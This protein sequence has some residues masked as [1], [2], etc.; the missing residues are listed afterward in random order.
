MTARRKLC[1]IACP[2][3]RPELELVAA[4]ADADISCRFLEMALHNRSAEALRETLQNAIDTTAG[5]DAIAV[6]Y[7]V[8]NRG[9]IGIVARQ[10]PL[11]IPRTHDCIGLLLGS[12]SRYLEELEKEPGT[13]FQS[14]GWLR[15][16]HDAG[17]QGEL[18]FGPNSN[19]NFERLAARYGDEAARYLVEELEAFLVHYKRLSYV[20]TPIAETAA[21]AAE[22]RSI[23]AAQGLE[24]HPLQGDIGWL[25]RLLKGPWPDEEFLTV[26]PGQRVVLANGDRLIE[27]A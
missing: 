16:A 27:A 24:Y 3:L 12:S 11:V 17:S 13:Y 25:Q 23:A 10:I 26:H 15:A 14:A 22:A 4:E 9:I 20:A 7:G 1:V 2:S 18:T 19:V 6:G 21:L 5:C 8:C